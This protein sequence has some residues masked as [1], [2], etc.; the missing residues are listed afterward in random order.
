MEAWVIA[1]IVFVFAAL[2]E[3]VSLFSFS[4]HWFGGADM[5]CNI[6]STICPN[7]C[8]RCKFLKAQTAFHQV[9]CNSLQDEAEKALRDEEEERQL[10]HDRPH[11][12]GRLPHPLP[13]LQRPLLDRCLLDENILTTG[14]LSR[15]RNSTWADK[16]SLVKDKA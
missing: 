3:Y 16:L 4:R 12:L 9:H 11:L 6:L 7:R 14:V 5:I 15:K 8:T 13:R 10:R 2:M 1:C